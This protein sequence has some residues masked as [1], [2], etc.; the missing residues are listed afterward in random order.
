MRPSGGQEVTDEEMKEVMELALTT[1]NVFESRDGLRHEDIDIPFVR[2]SSQRIVVVE[3]RD[4]P[5][6][7]KGLGETT[8]SIDGKYFTSIINLAGPAKSGRQDFAIAW[9]VIQ[10]ICLAYAGDFKD[11]DAVCNIIAANAA[12]GWVGMEQGQ[13]E[14]LIN[15][16]G[17]TD[18]EHLG[19]KNYKYRFLGF[20]FNEF[21][22]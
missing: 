6:V 12:A 17:M 9:S 4:M 5:E 2:P 21:I 13:A 15:S 3:D 16:Y 8:V 14:K 11:S 19:S 18:L 10:A 20:V 1:V 22:K 7:L